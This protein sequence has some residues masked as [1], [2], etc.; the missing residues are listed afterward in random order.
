M[1]TGATGV[2]ATGLNSDQLILFNQARSRAQGR[3]QSLLK[4][5]DALLCPQYDQEYCSK[6]TDVA[7]KIQA[8]A[9]LS[10]GARPLPGCLCCHTPLRLTLM[11][12]TQSCGEQS[13]ERPRQTCG[14]QRQWCVRSLA[15]LALQAGCR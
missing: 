5:A 1:L 9:A 2:M 13:S 15:P 10:G 14:R 8:V 6:A 7:A 11:A 4:G 12:C 3:K